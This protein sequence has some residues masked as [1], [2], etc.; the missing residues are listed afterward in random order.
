MLFLMLVTI[1][2]MK[3]KSE[4]VLSMGLFLPNDLFFSIWW[5]LCTDFVFLH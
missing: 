2:P 1:L 3:A 5:Q 4:D